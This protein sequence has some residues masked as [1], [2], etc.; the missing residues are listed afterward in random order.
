MRNFFNGFLKILWRIYRSFPVSSKVRG[1]IGAF[2]YERFPSFYCKM[3]FLIQNPPFDRKT[4]L[5]QN[6]DVA[7]SGMDPYEHYVR[8]GKAEGRKAGAD[9]QFFHRNDY[10]E[11]IR[12]YDTLDAQA[13]SGMIRRL[14]NF[15][16]WPIISVLMP[17]YNPKR[18]WLKAAIDSVRRQI[19]PYWE[20]CIADDASTDPAIRPFLEQCAK[21]DTR[22][23]LVFREKN[24]NISAASNSAFELARGDWI[25]LLDQDDLLSENALF[26]VAETLQRYPDARLIYS[27]EDKIDAEGRRQHPYFKCDWN[28]DL[29][30]SHNMVSHLGVFHAGMFR[31]LKGF[32]PGTDGA[33]DYDLVLRCLE[34]IGEDKIRHIPRVL[35][36]WRIHKASA[37]ADLHAKPY[38]LQAGEKALNESFE[39]R[40]IRATAEREGHGYRVCY[41][42]PSM[43]PQVSIIIPTKNGLPLLRKCIRSIRRKTRY[44]NYE[45]LI[46]DNGSEDGPTLRY[47]KEIQKVLRFRVI[48]DERP[49]NFSAL[50]NAAVRKAAGEVVCL[51]N[52]DI[53][54]ITPEWLSEM[55]SLVL[56]PGVGAV[57]ARLWYPDRTLQHGGVITGLGGCAGH[58]HKRLPQGSPGY[59]WR[60][61][62]MQSFS[63]VTAACLVI[64]R[65]IYEMVGGLNEQ[66]LPVA[67]NDVDF[68]LRV[69][70]AGYRNLWTP[71]AEL[72]HHESASRGFE[73]TA[74]KI[75]R[76]GKEIEYMKKRWGDRLLKDPAYS[77][78]LTLDYED[79]SLAWP[80]RYPR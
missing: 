28:Y 53:E 80:P 55:V 31:E 79:F 75:V 8:F 48:R 72:W 10:E 57:S 3:E 1:K 59:F 42:L 64:N 76:F 4:Y 19:Y 39:R 78:N 58:S 40:G 70:E 12:R 74:E 73:D 7:K 11:W 62:S 22:I 30:L 71:Y 47:L 35:Y 5:R 52:N 77:P 25:A 46:I 17:V 38:A 2:F 63:A 50:N 56:Q 69:R 6:P 49:F 26:W 44:P 16:F 67:F 54:V 43:C 14:E 21:E 9:P 24:G 32:R 29:F 65:N 36:H 27:D 45:I 33:Q 15:V 20:L 68:C 61:V 41:A 13:R 18:N 23:K 66:D 37:A 34:V 60:A 51:L